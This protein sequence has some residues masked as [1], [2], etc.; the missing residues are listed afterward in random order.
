MYKFV[1]FIVVFAF[2]LYLNVTNSFR[3]NDLAPGL[4]NPITIDQVM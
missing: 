4:F 3:I 1:L 2:F